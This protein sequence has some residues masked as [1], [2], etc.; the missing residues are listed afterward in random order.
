MRLIEIQ[1]PKILEDPTTFISQEYTSG[2]TL[3]VEDSAKFADNDL[4]LIGGLGNEKSEVTD[5]TATP[6]NKTSFT[7]TALDH[8]HD[9][10]ESIEKVLY[11]QFDIQYRETSTDSWTSLDTGVEFDWKDEQTVYVHSDGA[12]AYQ[13][14]VRYY[15]S[16]TASYSGWSDTTSG[17]GLSRDQVG[18]MIE[19]VR[20][21]A[22][23]EDGQIED[24]EIIDYFNYAQ[25]AVTSFRS[26]RWPWLLTTTTYTTTAATEGPYNEYE[27]PS[28]FDSGFRVRFRYDDGTSDIN[29]FLK[30]LPFTEFKNKYKDEDADTDD[31][32]KNYTYDEVNDY[33]LI[34]PKTESAGYTVELYYYK[35]LTDLDSY[36]DTTSVPLPE[37][38]INYATAKVWRRKDNFEKHDEY[39]NDFA[40]SLRMLENM[41]V[42]S[43]HPKALKIWRGRKAM[44]RMYGDRRSYSDSDRE[45]YY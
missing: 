14:R 26:K 4:V 25:D 21:F 8:D 20:R 41:R 9:T 30:Y 7:I 16:A 44:S 27:L 2:T 19:Q 17:A 34:G 31:N 13:Y 10:D 3:Y 40:N 6:P 38:L 36:G 12:A 33:L 37:V 35:S 5:L 28:D 1:N 42:E 24:D 43:H 23:D 18:S 11:D 29:Y 22:E 45:N 15:N 32:A 39:M